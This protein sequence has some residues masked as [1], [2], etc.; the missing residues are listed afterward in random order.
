MCAH[1]IASFVCAHMFFSMLLNSVVCWRVC[2]CVCV[3]VCVCV[4][5]CVFVCV[6]VCVCLCVCVCVCVC[7][8]ACVCVRYVFSHRVLAVLPEAIKHGVTADSG[9]QQVLDI[10]TPPVHLHASI[11]ASVN[12]LCCVSPAMIEHVAIMHVRAQK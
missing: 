3:S 9:V 6:C 1:S 8:C 12:Q 5:L 7:V 10:S 2:V 11:Y 4:C